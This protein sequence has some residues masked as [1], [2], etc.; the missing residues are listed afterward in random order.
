MNMIDLPSAHDP[1]HETRHFFE[2]LLHSALLNNSVG[3][4]VVLVKKTLRN[5]KS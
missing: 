3:L 2:S 5:S 1:L 4:Y